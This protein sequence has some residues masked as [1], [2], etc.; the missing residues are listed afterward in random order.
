MLAAPRRLQFSTWPGNIDRRTRSAGFIRRWF[1]GSIVWP[2]RIDGSLNRFPSRTARGWCHDLNQMGAFGTS[3][4]FPAA[5]RNLQ[6]WGNLRICFD[7]CELSK[8]RACFSLRDRPRSIWHD[9]GPSAGWRL[10]C[11]KSVIF[12]ASSAKLK[13][14]LSRCS[15]GFELGHL[16]TLIFNWRRSNEIKLHRSFGRRNGGDNF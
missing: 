11:E 1:F 7:A 4:A 8:G 16:K 6:P 10:L 2:S 15:S 5:Q 12:S 14:W 9:T 3:S 13:W